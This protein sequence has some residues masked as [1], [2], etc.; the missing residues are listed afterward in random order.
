[1]FTN[2][3]ERFAS[4]YNNKQR[5]SEEREEKTWFGSDNNKSII[6]NWGIKTY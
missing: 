5:K 4:R 6:G 3:D 1:M 2:V